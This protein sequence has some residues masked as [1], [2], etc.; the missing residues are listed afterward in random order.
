MT[1]ANIAHPPIASQEE[2]LAARKEL[3]ANEKEATR[4]RDA[5]SAQRRRLPMVRIDKDYVFAGTNGPTR[6]LDLFDG[7][8][9]LIIYHF[10][11]DPR[12]DA[13]CPGCTGYVD[14]LG[15]LRMLHDRDTAF[16]LVSRAP[17]AKLE[18]YKVRRGWNLPWFSSYETDFN[19]DFHVTFDESVTPIEYNFRSKAEYEHRGTPFAVEQPSEGHGISVFFRLHDG[20]L[21][22]L[23]GLCPRHR[24]AHRRLQPARPD[25]VWPAGGLG[26]L[27]ARLAAKADV[28]LVRQPCAAPSRRCS[29]SSLEPGATDKEIREASRQF[30]RTLSGF[31]RR[32][33]S[34]LPFPALRTA[35]YPVRAMTSSRRPWPPY[36]RRSSR[37]ETMPGRIM[38][39]ASRPNE[40]E[41]AVRSFGCTGWL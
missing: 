14:A 3:L 37:G 30:V 26:R 17:L 28:R 33:R 6:L 18:A 5:L 22:H 27:T 8:R 19:Y 39:H 12:W 7:R 38:H 2:W 34:P 11:F 31:T 15:D 13:G 24:R 21:P 4:A 1:T 20:G 40:Q 29:I 35:P 9:Q 41:H 10:M 23:F 16:A 36:W 32:K 25:A